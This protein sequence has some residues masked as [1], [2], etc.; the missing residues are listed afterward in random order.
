MCLR[1]ESYSDLN[2]TCLTKVL[3]DGFVAVMS[4]YVRLITD[5]NCN[6]L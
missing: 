3:E 6:T 4:M 1:Y 5:I 2:M